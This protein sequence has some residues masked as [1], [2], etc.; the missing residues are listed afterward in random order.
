MARQKNY[1]EAH[2]LQQQA[3]TMEDGER[4]KYAEEV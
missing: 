4:Q 1:S 2:S 3:N